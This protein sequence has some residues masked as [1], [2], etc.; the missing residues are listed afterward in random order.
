MRGH[1]CTRSH[2][3]IETACIDYFAIPYAFVM[4]V[5]VDMIVGD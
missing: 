2:N 1:I 3:L 5:Q 4:L